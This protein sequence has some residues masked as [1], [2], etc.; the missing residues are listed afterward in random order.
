[1]PA[2]TGGGQKPGRYRDPGSPRKVVEPGPRDPPP[3]PAQGTHPQ[4]EVPPTP[5]NPLSP[6][7]GLCFHAAASDAS[8]HVT[9]PAL[10]PPQRKTHHSL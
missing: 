9:F 3:T 10:P 1:M 7:L 8:G 5:N 2:L 6:A 4:T